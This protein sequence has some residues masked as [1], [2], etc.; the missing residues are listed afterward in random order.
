MTPERPVN[1]FFVEPFVSPMEPLNPIEHDHDH[2]YVDV[3]S[4]EAQFREFQ[5]QMG[6]LTSVI[7]RGRI[8]LAT[9]HTG[10]GKSALL[11]R[12]AAWVIAGL[13]EQGKDAKVVDASLTFAVSEPTGMV[14]RIT[15][16]SDRLFDLMR[17]EN[18]IQSTA[19]EEFRQDR[20]EY[21]R[22]FDNLSF[23]LPENNVLILMLP[24][25]E[26][27]WREVVKYASL[28]R[29]RVLLMMES[30]RLDHEAVQQINVGV[31]RHTKPIVLEVGP[32]KDGDVK[33]FVDA[34][35]NRQGI[36]GR[37]PRMSDETVVSVG[38]RMATVAQLQRSMHSTYEFRMRQAD[39]G[40]DAWVTME[41]ILAD[42]ERSSVDG[43]GA[44]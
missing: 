28:V 17:R 7:N 36:P 10:C 30:S 12:C 8:V 6:D 35:L 9:G 22:V 27:L 20:R 32:L 18:L 31:E 3:D 42:S 24:S 33:R 15:T 26:D 1:P 38:S 44:L 43:S 5:R 19:I 13:K 34:R 4:S 37:F 29:G 23:F 21:V 14:E 39:Y 25:P 40:D 2:L 41:D 16:V 11:N